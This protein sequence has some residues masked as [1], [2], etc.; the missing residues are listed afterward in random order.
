[1]ELLDAVP[2]Q[3][4]YCDYWD[5]SVAMG[6]DIRPPTSGLNYVGITLE[7]RSSPVCFMYDTLASASLGRRRCDAY[8]STKY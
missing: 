3:I 2:L 5:T 6:V 4:K 7:I 8:L 1:M